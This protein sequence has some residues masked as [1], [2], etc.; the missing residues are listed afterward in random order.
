MPEAAVMYGVWC[1]KI[2][3]TMLWGCQKHTQDVHNKACIKQQQEQ[4]NKHV[5]MRQQ[6][7]A[8]C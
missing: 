4:A 2:S 6:A 3:A 5:A 7:H 8:M 1:K